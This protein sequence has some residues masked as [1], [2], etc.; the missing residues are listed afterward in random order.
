MEPSEQDIIKNHT[1]EIPVTIITGFLGAGKTTLLN[2]IL[3]NQKGIKTAVLVNEFGSIG[4]DNDLITKTEEDVIELTNGCICCTI[5]DELLDAINRILSENKS[6]EYLIIETTGLADPLPVAMTINSARELLR[7]DSI[8][9]LVDCDNFSDDTFNSKVA[10]SQILYGDIILLNKCDLVSKD[11]L[12][13]IESRLSE[14]KRNPRLLRSV[15]GDVPL[16]LIL[17]VG[18]FKSDVIASSSIEHEH[19]HEHDE[20]SIEGFKSFSFESQSSISLRKFQ[21]FLNKIPSTIYRAK[22][23]LWFDQSEITHIFHLAGKRLTLDDSMTNRKK[24]NKI[25]FIGKNID[26]SKLYSQLQDCVLNTNENSRC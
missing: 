4:I 20:L 1:R 24:E 2:R 11:R 10:R 17:S 5:N 14:I 7:L 15:K 25:V 19:E 22:G 3:T 23:I 26:S 16:P 18:L 8:I 12:A 21:N 9:T 6:I 13:I